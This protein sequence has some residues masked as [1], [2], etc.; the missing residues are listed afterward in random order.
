MRKLA[1][2]LA[3]VLVAAL[4]AAPGVEA[5]VRTGPSGTA[6]YTPPSPL[7]G[8]KHGDLI[9]ARKITTSAALAGASSSWLVLYRSPG[10][11][12]KPNAVSGVV[13]LPR[14]KAPKG[15]FKSVSWTHGTS[16]IADKCA[17]SRASGDNE[18]NVYQSYS[19]PLL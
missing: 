17:P 16:G 12:G 4:A 9:W 19:Y 5:K 10:S 1:P 13:S 6:F 14:G 15:G 7:P 2:L 8:K 18:A 3:T 11:D